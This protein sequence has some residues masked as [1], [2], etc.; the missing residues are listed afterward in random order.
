LNE[1][2]LKYCIV[3]KQNEV[4]A[5]NHFIKLLINKSI[6]QYV[7]CKQTVHCLINRSVKTKNNT[8]WEEDKR[9]VTWEISRECNNNKSIKVKTVNWSD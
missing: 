1:L 8:M 7:K 3:H 4:N 5:H 2:Q 6:M 9:M